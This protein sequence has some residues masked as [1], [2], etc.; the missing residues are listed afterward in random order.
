MVDEPLP[1][2]DPEDVPDYSRLHRL[3][4]RRFVVLGAGP[5]LG[6][7]TAHALRA[8]GARL[9]CV[10]RLRDRAEKVANEVSGLA[11]HADAT[12]R[13]EL[14]AAFARAEDEL[15]G[16]DGVVDVIGGNTQRSLLEATDDDWDAVFAVSFRHAA[17]AVQYGGRAITRA[18]GGTMAFV[19]SA[20]AYGTAPDCGAYS[21][22]KAALGGLVRS[23]ALEL[24]PA[25]IRI[26]AV[27]PTLIA[28]PG[29]LGAGPPGQAANHVRA[30]AA[31]TPTR[32]INSTRD[33]ASVLL[34]LSSELSSNI[35]GQTIGIS[36]GRPIL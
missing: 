18:G 8:N 1:Y 12:K 6:R 21:S 28:S 17:L 19:S 30:S 4:G 22:A 15:S 14:E 10:D 27:A 3:D 11:I 25:G 32:R 26:N 16:I 7:Q 36:G 35:S 23:A 34:F 33:I 31:A 13:G 20:L 29:T 24:G 2:F 9:V 5:G